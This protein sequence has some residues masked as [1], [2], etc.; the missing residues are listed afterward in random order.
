M[1]RWRQLTE[2]G[3]VVLGPMAK[4]SSTMRAMVSIGVESRMLTPP[5]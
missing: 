2:A 1:R 5:L 4:S 3:R